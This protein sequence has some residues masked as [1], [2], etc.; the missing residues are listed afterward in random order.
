M[1]NYTKKLN[2]VKDLYPK[3]KDLND[4]WVWNLYNSICEQQTIKEFITQT[5]N[6]E[7]TKQELLKRFPNQTTE[8]RTYLVNK[9]DYKVY[10][11]SIW[12]SKTQF[13][14]IKDINI[15]MDSFGWFPT[16][17]QNPSSQTKSGRFSEENLKILSQNSNTLHVKYEAKYDIMINSDKYDYFYHLIPDILYEK[18]ELMGLTPKNKEKIAPHPERIYVL[19]S[20]PKKYFEQIA[21]KLWMTWPEETRKLIQYYYLL[22]IDAKNLIK[23]R[24]VKFYNDSAFAVY[25]GSSA[26]WTYDNIPPKYIKLKNKILVNP[27]KD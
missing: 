19:K 7:K 26:F 22:E 6:D 13:K 27:K 11:M 24:Q 16:W 12:F 10:K 17:I 18:V 14:N 21:I 20:I 8:I 9:E 4:T 5:I 3:L 2:E 25:D 1:N 23:E 15:F